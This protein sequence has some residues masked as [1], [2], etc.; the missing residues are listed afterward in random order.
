M[1]TQLVIG[2]VKLTS[3]IIS[4]NVGKGWM[5]GRQG[6]TPL[7]FEGSSSNMC[8]ESRSRLS[9]SP[10]CFQHQIFFALLIHLLTMFCLSITGK[11]QWLH[12]VQELPTVAP[13]V[14]PP[15]QP[16]YTTINF[17]VQVQ[18]WFVL[19]LPQQVQVNVEVT[20][21]NYHTTMLLP[22]IIFPFPAVATTRVVDILAMAILMKNSSM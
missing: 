17:T 20:D 6:A 16:C 14:P 1:L 10:I 13:Q 15:V 19:P 18:P 3:T 5:S 11:A 21:K 22:T 2:D 12:L 4:M 9:P 8:N 7:L